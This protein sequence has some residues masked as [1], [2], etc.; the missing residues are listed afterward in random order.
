M[1]RDFAIKIFAVL[2]SLW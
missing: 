2:L 1:I